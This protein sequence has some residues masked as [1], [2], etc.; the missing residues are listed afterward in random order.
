[1]IPI[2]QVL[3]EYDRP[4]IN[5]SE[6]DY[7]MCIE[8]LREMDE[9]TTHVRVTNLLFPHAFVIPMSPEV[10]ITQWHVPVDDVTTYWY[11][12]F[13]SYAEPLNKQQMRDQRLELFE[14]PDYRS[15]RN[16]SNDY[17]FDP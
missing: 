5:V 11:A 3:R 13:T 6:T 10:T 12:I 2:T 9:T 1:N 14:L 17:G 4:T 16:K 7:G 8:T 15:R